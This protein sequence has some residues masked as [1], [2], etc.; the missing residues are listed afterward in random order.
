LRQNF[1]L[2]W[3]AAWTRG[4][5][6]Q[7]QRRASH[8]TQKSARSVPASRSTWQTARCDARPWR[9]VRRIPRSC[10]RRWRRWS[11]RASGQSHAS[12]SRVAGP[13][14]SSVHL[15]DLMAVRQRSC[16]RPL[17]AT[18]WPPAQMGSAN[19][20]PSGQR[21][22]TPWKWS[23]FVIRRFDRSSSLALLLNPR[24]GSISAGAG[25]SEIV[26]V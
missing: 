4:T 3:M 7:C 2:S 20:I 15:Q 18:A 26:T 23:D 25:V 14:G 17:Y 10:R 12:G 1:G 6:A 22:R 11:L 21:R 13:V 5:T 8:R 19:D 24:H 9:R 16:V